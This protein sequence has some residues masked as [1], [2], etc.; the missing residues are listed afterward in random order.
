MDANE[1]VEFV[2]EM[3]V[4]VLVEDLQLDEDVE[5]YGA[6]L[7]F[8]VGQKVGSSEVEDKGCSHLEHGLADD[9]R[10]HREADNGRAAG[11]GRTVKDLIRGRVG[12]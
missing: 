12:G 11:C 4:V 8:W 2:V 3:T 7:L 9:H 5:D 10:P 1:D 6:H